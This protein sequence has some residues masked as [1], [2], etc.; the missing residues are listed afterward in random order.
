MFK[1]SHLRQNP[2]TFLK[3]P[4]LFMTTHNRHIESLCSDKDPTTEWPLWRLCVAT[5]GV[6]HTGPGWGSLSVHH[7]VISRVTQRLT[8]VW[9][10]N[11]GQVL[12]RGQRSKRLHTQRFA[13]GSGFGFWVF[14]TVLLCS[15]GWPRTQHHQASL[16]LSMLLLSQSLKHG[17]YR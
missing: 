9:G 14:E 7:R 3:F 5:M 13:G 2:L 17:D 10:W 8:A 1:I 12:H 16:A 15:P 6:L 11:K 4:C